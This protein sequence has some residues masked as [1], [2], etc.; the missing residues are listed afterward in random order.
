MPAVP[1]SQIR[2]VPQAPR[3]DVGAFIPPSNPA[4]GLDLFTKA[5][6]LPLMFETLDIQRARNKAEKAKLDLD[7]KQLTFT[8]QNF[9]AI[10]SAQQAAAQQKA[11]YDAQVAEIELGRKRLEA[12]KLE[13]DVAQG[14]L[15]DESRVNTLLFPRANVP[16]TEDLLEDETALGEDVSPA[17]PEY[18]DDPA[19][20]QP[21]FRTVGAWFTPNQN[22]RELAERKA[23]QRVAALVPEGGVTERELAE[24]RTKAQQ[25]REELKP[26]ETTKTVKDAKGIPMQY[27][28][29][30]VGDEVV[31]L[32][33]F[34]RIDKQE[35]YKLR[36]AQK[37]KDE[38]YAERQGEEGPEGRATRLS[39]LNKLTTALE[40]WNEVAQKD[41]ATVSRTRVLSF[42]PDKIQTAFQSKA[43]LAQNQVRSAIQSSLKEALG[44]AFTQKEGEALMA[45]AFDL[46]TTQEINALLVTQAIKLAET[47]MRD[48]KAQED[49][50][51]RNGT[52]VGFVPASGLV[53]A[54]GSANVARA[55]QIMDDIRS[56][57]ASGN[58]GSAAPA[59]TTL[60]PE[61]LKKAVSYL[62]RPAP[63]PTP[64]PTP[65]PTPTGP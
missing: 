60:S 44:G 65:K 38:A 25:I 64:T 32:K 21:D 40:V 34:P 17:Q 2:V 42:L 20:Y 52:L 13:Q 7:E 45:R 62:R 49:Y 39:N 59:A 43:V 63:T 46:T 23:D 1:T 30:A 35:L 41:G 37:V 57:T 26:R 6:Q 11:A 10:Q 24:I 3:V 14:R 12:E 5:A 61:Q 47:M 29:V 56:R 9:G 27:D 55:E 54:D 48:R 28:V 4:G 22:A 16:A 36:P 53:A 50:F 18:P 19:A 15:A 58:A 8:A 31:E 33:G 51:D